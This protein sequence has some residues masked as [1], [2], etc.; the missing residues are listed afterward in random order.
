MEWSLDHASASI[1][2]DEYMTYVMC[3]VLVL[4][5]TQKKPPG[6]VFSCFGSTVRNTTSLLAESNN[7]KSHPLNERVRLPGAFVCIAE[8]PF[9]YVVLCFIATAWIAWWVR[10]FAAVKSPTKNL[11]G[12][13]SSSLLAGGY[14]TIML[15][16]SH[17]AS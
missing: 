2:I 1:G 10:K 15:Y 5:W 11:N 8:M 12:P 4:F 17:P 9:P 16:W 7:C 13:A 6:D 3:F 14:C